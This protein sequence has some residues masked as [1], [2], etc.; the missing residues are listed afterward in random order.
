MAPRAGVT[1]VFTSPQL[2]SRAPRPVTPPL[3]PVSLARHYLVT[4][5]PP[6]SAAQSA[7]VDTVLIWGPPTRHPSSA[8][9]ARIGEVN[10]RS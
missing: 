7:R 4:R 2:P 5:G 3:A 8:P 9:A 1:A 6:Q 10:M